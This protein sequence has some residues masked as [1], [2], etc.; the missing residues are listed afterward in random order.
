MAR[1][2]WAASGNGRQV[3]L[4]ASSPVGLLLTGQCG[5]SERSDPGMT[6][7]PEG[8]QL[9]RT[10]TKKRRMRGDWRR[11]PKIHEERK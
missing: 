2:V 1:R 6:M 3:A 10:R 8:C 11:E 7:P 9:A 5:G 4:I